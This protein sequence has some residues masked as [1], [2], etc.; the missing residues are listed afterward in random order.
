MLGS[1][2]A[3]E[4][5][6]LVPPLHHAVSEVDGVPVHGEISI[7]HRVVL[8]AIRIGSDKMHGEALGEALDQERALIVP[9]QQFQ[10]HKVEDVRQS[11]ISGA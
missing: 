2:E 1:S 10:V 6:G 8:R 4:G 3:I 7:A 11:F 9:S 5:L